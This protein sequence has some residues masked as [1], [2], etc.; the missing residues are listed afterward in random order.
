MGHCKHCFYWEHLNQQESPLT[1]AEVDKIAK[2]MGRLYQLIITGG[3]PFL[4]EDFTA[5]VERFCIHNS[6]YHLSIATS[7]YYPDRVENAV[8]KLLE[9]YPQ[10]KISVGLPI[11]G[12]AELND[13]IRGIRGFYK[14]T[15]E[16]LLRLKKLKQNKA[17][18][19]VLIDMTISSFNRSRLL[20][21]YNHIFNDLKPDFINAI[22]T[23]GNPQEPEARQIDAE[24]VLK[25]F[26]RMEEDIRNGR[27]QGYGF[28]SKLLQA[29]DIVLR[30]TALEIYKNNTYCLPCQAGRTVGV[31]MPEGDVYACELREESIGNLRQFNYDFHALWQSDNAFKIRQEIFQSRCTCYHQCFLSN[32]LFWNWKAWPRILGE[33]TK[34]KGHKPLQI[35]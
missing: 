16:T 20:E 10:L 31:M 25:L 23:R 24:E 2:S 1:V 28:L 5:L 33:W 7:G 3:E 14:K 29:K 8:I 13:E 18:L 19:S 9:K 34:I 35:P 15:T 27:V 17:Q 11:E 30:Q 12:P 21:T 4:R 26:S 32:T 6:L 22:L